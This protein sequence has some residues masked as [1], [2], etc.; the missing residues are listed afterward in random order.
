M[1]PQFHPTG[2]DHSGSG[3]AGA[4]L[5]KASARRGSSLQRQR[6]ALT[7]LKT[8]RPS[9]SC[10]TR[11]R[12]V[13]RQYLEMPVRPG[14]SPEGGVHT[15]AARLGADFVL[16]FPS[17]AESLQAVQLRLARWRVP[18]RPRPFR[19]GRRCHRHRGKPRSKNFSLLRR[20]RR[21]AA[22]IRLGGNGICESGVYVRHGRQCAGEVSVEWKSFDSKTLNGQAEA[23]GSMTSL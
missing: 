15:Y 3:V 4:L 12:V 11:R 6:L 2:L 13:V 14:V 22:S 8:L 20:C 18:I 23:A 16:K 21:R 17:P 9:P 10:A 7:C 1:I 5:K 19:E